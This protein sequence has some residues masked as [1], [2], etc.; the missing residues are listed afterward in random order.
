MFV[1]APGTVMGQAP[2]NGAR[3]DFVRSVIAAHGVNCDADARIQ[4][5]FSPAQRL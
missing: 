3:D 5:R 1:R 2:V 4:L